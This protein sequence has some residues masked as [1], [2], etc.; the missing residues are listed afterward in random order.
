MSP[1]DKK[2]P[3]LEAWAMDTAAALAPQ[4]QGVDRVRIALGLI[5]AR[6]LECRHISGE[7]VIKAGSNQVIAALA[8]HLGDRSEKMERFAIKIAEKY[9]GEIVMEPRSKLIIQ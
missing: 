1:S 5:Q 3:V 4:L 2:L 8:I 7:Y 9:A 6:A